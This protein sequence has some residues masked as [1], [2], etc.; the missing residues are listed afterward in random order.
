MDSTVSKEFNCTFAES[1]HHILQCFSRVRPLKEHVKYMQTESKLIKIVLWLLRRHILVEMNVFIILMLPR[2]DGE[3]NDTNHEI[4]QKFNDE[5]THEL[6]VDF[7]DIHEKQ[8]LDQIADNSSEYL[9]LKR[10]CIYFRGKYDIEEIMWRENVDRN[11]LV[12]ILE[13][14]KDILVRCIV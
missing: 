10:L 4:S 5:N 1:F 9:L 3:N 2:K 8:Y 14:Y 12:K 11:E 6:E 13:T 7:L